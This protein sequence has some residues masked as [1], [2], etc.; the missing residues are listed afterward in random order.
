MPD[1]TQLLFDLLPFLAIGFTAQMIDG[2]L[3][4]A[5]GVTTQ[6]LLLD[7]PQ[8][9]NKAVIHATSTDGKAVA[10]FFEHADLPDNPTIKKQI[11]AAMHWKTPLEKMHLIRNPVMLLV[12][13]DDKVVGTQ[14]SITLAG[15]IPGA[16][17]I[18]FKNATHHLQFEAPA[19]FAQI[20]LTFLAVDETVPA[21]QNP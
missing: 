13:T 12:G 1:L 19:A 10:A 5:V 15:L 21:K 18:Q 11:Q 4:M 20:V 2:A 3:G 17:L 6:T 9:I 16:W 14:S 8:R 7:S